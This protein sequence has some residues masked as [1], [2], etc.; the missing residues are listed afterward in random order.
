MRSHP[1]SNIKKGAFTILLH[2]VPEKH[3]LNCP[4]LLS[5]YLL[6]E[7]ATILILQMRKMRYRGCEWFTHNLPLPLV[8][9]AR[10]QTQPC[11]L[12]ILCTCLLPTEPRCSPDPASCISLATFSKGKGGNLQ[13]IQSK[14][15][16]KSALSPWDQP[17]FVGIHSNGK[18]GS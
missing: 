9:R 6:H 11:A 13:A 15:L 5:L 10:T 18:S 2:C 14:H 4:F 12:F 8:V 1:F 16:Y 3:I 17:A 7:V